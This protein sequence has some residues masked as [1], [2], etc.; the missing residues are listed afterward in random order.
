MPSNVTKSKRTWPSA[1]A[2]TARRPTTSARRATA[3]PID[4]R[5][6]GRDVRVA[7]CLVAHQRDPAV[8][9]DGHVGADLRFVDLL[10]A[11]RDAALL[12]SLVDCRPALMLELCGNLVSG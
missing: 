8:L 11:H 3:R 6:S 1:E 2:P 12:D 4:D 10:S 5:A 7:L 9:H